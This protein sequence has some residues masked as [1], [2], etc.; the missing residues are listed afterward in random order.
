M[1]FWMRGQMPIVQHLMFM[2]MSVVEN[3]YAQERR[4]CIGH[5]VTHM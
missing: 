5:L 4:E 3:A 2:L 1:V